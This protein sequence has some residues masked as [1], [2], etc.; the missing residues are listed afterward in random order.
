MKIS[1]NDAGVIIKEWITTSILPKMSNDNDVV[2]FAISFL[3]GY[4]LDKLSQSVASKLSIL[5]DSDGTLNIDEMSAQAKN[6][7]KDSFNG[8]LHLSKLGEMDLEKLNLA[9]D[10]D[11]EDIDNIVAIAKK[12]AR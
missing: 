5:A 12:Y 10:I 6:L 7:L 1:V 4:K 11:S 3:L 2:K 8:N 9:Y